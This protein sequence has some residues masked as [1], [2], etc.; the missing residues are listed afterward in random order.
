MKKRRSQLVKKERMTVGCA[1]LLQKAMHAQTW[2]EAYMALYPPKA[3]AR[4]ELLRKPRSGEPMCHND[5]VNDDM[6][7][8][9]GKKKWYSSNIIR[10]FAN[11]ALDVVRDVLVLVQG[12]TITGHGI[13]LGGFVRGALQKMAGANIR[14]VVVAVN[15][16]NSHWAVACVDQRTVAYYDSKYDDRRAA[17]ACGAIVAVAGARKMLKG[18]TMCCQQPNDV[19][20]GVYACA[21]MLH[22]VYGAEVPSGTVYED[23]I[24]K[25]RHLVATRILECS[26]GKTMGLKRPMLRPS[27]ADEE[28]PEE[29][30]VL[31]SD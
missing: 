17:I 24:E 31:S 10:A 2:L 7:A 13:R 5:P 21:N 8:R 26:E 19:D 28:R 16:D 23:N 29:T 30:I 25:L 27:A 9:L 6:I 14:R 4:A 22:L 11:A 1:V 12:A 3:G 18:P 15:S 20:C